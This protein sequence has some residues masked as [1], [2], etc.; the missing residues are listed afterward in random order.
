MMTSGIRGGLAMRRSVLLLLAATLVP[1]LCLAMDE[2]DPF[3]WLEEVEGQRALAWAKEQNA[4]TLPE[5]ESR[6]ENMPWDFKGADCL[7]PDYRKC[8]VSLSR[9]GA[10]ATVVREF[11]TVTKAFVP[12]GFTLAEAKSS[13][14]WRDAD[15]LWVGTDFGPGSLTTSGYPR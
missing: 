9:G 3:A 7:A 12:G 11:D 15:T 10:D 13:T 5:L 1:R 2:P 8:L 6:P 14:G 4:R